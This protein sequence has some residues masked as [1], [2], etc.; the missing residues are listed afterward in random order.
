MRYPQGPLAAALVIATS[1]PAPPCAHG[2]RHAARG[3]W[4]GRQAVSRF[5]IGVANCFVVY[6]S[7]WDF[8]YLEA[9]Y[10]QRNE[11]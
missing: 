7:D 10:R 9:T 3:G 1:F 8:K 11:T 2:R 5:G 6:R 4:R